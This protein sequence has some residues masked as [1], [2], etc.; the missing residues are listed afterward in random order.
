LFAALGDDDAAELRRRCPLFEDIPR[1]SDRDVQKVLRELDMHDLATGLVGATEDARAAVE[2]NM[3][4]RAVRML[5][6]EI[7]YATR[8]GPSA[9]AKSRRIIRQIMHELIRNGEIAL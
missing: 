5:A 1:L 2:R 7:D 9:T 4:E 3:S 6:E 8:R